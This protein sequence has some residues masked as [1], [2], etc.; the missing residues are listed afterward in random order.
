MGNPKTENIALN[1]YAELLIKILINLIYLDPSLNMRRNVPLPRIF[2]RWLGAD[3]NQIDT[4]RKN[5]VLGR[6]WPTLAHSMIGYKRMRNLADCTLAVIKNNV[7]GDFIE[8]GVWRGGSCILMR[9][10]ANAAGQKKRKVF[11]ADSFVGLPEPDATNYPK[12]RNDN[13]HTKNDRLGVSLEQ[14]KENFAHY[15]LLGDNVIFLEGW[16]KDTLPTLGDE[17]FAIVR[18]DGD[19]YE[20][21]IQAIETLYPRLSKG[22]YLIVDDW[23]A[24]PACKQAVLDYRENEHITEDIIDIDGTGV[25]WKKLK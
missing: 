18:L 2:R 1:E 4:L 14:V 17:K 10:I 19:M 20:S 16:F 15:G 24:V 7:E 12:D 22:G 5:R 21:T 25:Y 11:V 8:T 6:D 23:G 3:K 13:H 9:G